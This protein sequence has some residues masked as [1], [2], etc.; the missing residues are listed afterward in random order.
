MQQLPGISDI[1]RR[2]DDLSAEGMY[3][4]Q[5][6]I[7]KSTDKPHDTS[8][9][10]KMMWA[11]LGALTSLAAGA[12]IPRALLRNKAATIAAMTAGGAITGYFAP[13]L[14][15]VVLEGKQGVVSPQR[16]RQ[17]FKDAYNISDRSIDRIKDDI[18]E[19]RENS[20]KSRQQIKT[21]GLMQ[22]VAKGAAKGTA[23]LA[24]AVGKSLTPGGWTRYYRRAGK[25]VPFGVS[26]F[27]WGVRG[28]AAYGGVRGGMALHSQLSGPRSRENYT[29]LLRNNVLAGNIHPSELSPQDLASVQNLGLK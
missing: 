17:V 1:N 19:I 11:G 3:R 8:L 20:E 10:S 29:T 25:S 16:A 12:A 14:G 4:L 24:G 23:T 21:A 27:K 2:I 22:F 13:S 18:A 28:T 5:Q 26:A 7:V 6:K 9:R 15:N